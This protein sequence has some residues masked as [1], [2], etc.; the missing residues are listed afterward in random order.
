MKSKVFVFLTVCAALVFTF[1]CS[2]GGSGD[3]ADD[4][5]T[6]TT[7]NI[8]IQLPGTPRAVSADD[9]DRFTVVVTSTPLNYN[10]EFSGTP[11]Q[12]MTVSTLVPGSY[13][14]SV[15]AYDD[16]LAD[17]NKL[18]FTGSATAVVKAGETASVSI[19]LTPVVGNLDVNVTFPGD[20]SS[21][22]RQRLKGVK[23]YYQNSFVTYNTNG[24]VSR[25]DYYIRDE[26]VTPKKY[27]FNSYVVFQFSDDQT[28]SSGIVY[29]ATGTAT[30]NIAITHDGSGNETSVKYTP[31]AG[32]GGYTITATYNADNTA[33]TELK[34]IRD[35]ETSTYN[36]RYFY[37]NGDMKGTESSWFVYLDEKWTY[38]GDQS[39]N[40]K[41]LMSYDAGTRIPVKFDHYMDGVL[42]DSETRTLAASGFYQKAEHKRSDGSLI[43]FVTY[44][45][46]I[47]LGDYYAQPATRTFIG[48]PNS[49][50]KEEDSF[51]E[52][53]TYYQL[54]TKTFQPAGTSIMMRTYEPGTVKAGV[55]NPLCFDVHTN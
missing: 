8:L 31:I 35:G 7:G 2:S 54:F 53:R 36:A 25:V 37:E 11:G 51:L 41:V 20:P 29:D 23:D 44:G 19:T 1:S 34:W 15:N 22:T 10:K 27:T 26:T 43:S 40:H 49:Y 42:A 46:P 38:V 24:I 39:N 4:D 17:A 3:S 48:D 28:R 50:P 47:E 13:D 6:G 52:S 45:N 16:D 55:I 14:I 30:S 32:S 9:V 21:V 12:N 33:I 5:P 18:V